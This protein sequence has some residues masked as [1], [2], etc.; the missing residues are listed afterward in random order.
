MGTITIEIKRKHFLNSEGYMSI[1]KCPLALATQEFFKDKNITVGGD[2][3]NNQYDRKINSYTFDDSFW[4]RTFIES[5]IEEAQKCLKSKKKFN[6]VFL[7][8]TKQ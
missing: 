4:K 1:S 7:E 3:L 6:N 2:C 5:K 8:L